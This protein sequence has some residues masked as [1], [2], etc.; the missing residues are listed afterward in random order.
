M[1]TAMH[2]G[3][4]TITTDRD[5]FDLAAIHR[6]LAKSYWSPGVPIA[7][8]ERS[9]ANSLCFGLFHG[10][11]QVGFARVI[12]DKATFAYLSDV[13]V[14]E[15]HRGKGLSKW[16]LEAIRGHEDLQGLRRFMLSTRDAHGL[17]SQFGFTELASPSRMME[18]HNADP[19]RPA[20][21]PAERPPDG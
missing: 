9:I 5:R 17:Y 20:P 12:T 16:L 1:S 8:V 14:L 19:Y 6:F 7:I 2:R 10:R 3:E 4:Y 18:I 11:D 21:S 13:Y 15:S